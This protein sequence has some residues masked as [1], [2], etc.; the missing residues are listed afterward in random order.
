MR[1][2]AS[3]SLRR[4]GEEL[5]VRAE[6]KNINSIKNVAKAISKCANLGKHFLKYTFLMSK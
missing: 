2:D 6:V 3:V 5:G 1:V 4:P